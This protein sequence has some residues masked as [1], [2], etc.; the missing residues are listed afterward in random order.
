MGRAVYKHASSIPDENLTAEN[1]PA[2][3]HIAEQI[4]IHAKYAPESIVLKGNSIDSDGRVD[5]KKQSIIMERGNLNSDKLFVGTY[6]HELGH[7]KNSGLH[8]KLNMGLFKLPYTLLLSATT[9]M[10]GIGLSAYA[11]M[12]DNKMLDLANG[13]FHHTGK[14]LIAAAIVNTVMIRTKEH[15]ADLFA[16]KHTGLLPSDYLDNSKRNG[17]IGNISKVIGDINGKLH[18]GYPTHLERD[19]VCKILGKKPKGNSFVERITKSDQQI[20]RN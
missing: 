14:Y 13:L 18:S 20:T 15:M 6:T 1:Y 7:L 3:A 19:I 8:S 10:Y 17:I 5:F 11:V 12:G 2:Y 9:N 4:S 16:Y